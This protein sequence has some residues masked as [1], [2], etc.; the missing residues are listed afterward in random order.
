[1]PFHAP[2]DAPRREDARWVP[3]RGATLRIAGR[4]V[5]SDRRGRIAVRVRFA[6][7]GLRG[8]RVRATGSPSRTVRI[9]VV[10]PR[11]RG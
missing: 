2:V 4:R 5:R 10:R 3:V 9:R 8:L 7:P 11:A 1:M 6:R